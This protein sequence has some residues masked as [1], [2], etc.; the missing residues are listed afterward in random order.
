MSILNFSLNGVRVSLH[1]ADPRQTLLEYVRDTAK[2]TGTKRSCL[3]GGCGAC[4]V[5]IQRFDATTNEW[6]AKPVNACLKPLAS[7]DG[8]VI[9]TVEGIGSERRGCHPVQERIAGHHG[10]QCGFCT[11]GFVMSAFSLLKEHGAPTAKQVVESF[12]GNIC[13][14]T[15]YRNLMNVS[16]SFS[17]EAS[18]GCKDLAAL[19]PPFDANNERL[20]QQPTPPAPS[21]KVLTAGGVTWH[22]PTSLKELLFLKAKEPRA[23]FVLGDTAKGIRSAAYETFDGKAPH[24][25]YLGN[26]PELNILAEHSGNLIAGGA[27]RIQHLVDAL[28]QRSSQ[29]PYAKHMAEAMTCIAQRHL[30]AEA[31]WAGNLWIT[32]TGFPG[33]LF[34]ILLAADA[35]VSYIARNEPEK[36]VSLGQLA[37]PGVVPPSALLTKL[38]IPLKAS[39]TFRYYRVGQRQF[40]SRSLA[41][42]AF[43]VD[44]DPSTRKVREA[45]VAIGVYALTPKRVASAEKIIVGGGLDTQTL[46]NAISAVHTE[47]DAEFSEETPFMTVNNPEGKDQYRRTLPDSFLFKFFQEAQ[48]ACGLKAWRLEDLGRLPTVP[49]QRSELTF[50]EHPGRE[51][52]PQLSAP[53][54]ATGEFRY[55]DDTPIQSLYGCL[56]LSECATGTLTGIDTSEALQSEGVLGVITATDIPGANSCGFVPGEEPVFVPVGGNIMTVGQQIAVVVATSYRLAKRAA[57]VVK[58]SVDGAGH[59]ALT[60]LEDAIQAKS[61]LEGA[62]L[63][64]VNQGNAEEALKKAHRVVQ[65][66]TF[67]QGQHA[68]PMEKQATLAVPEERG[69]MTLYSATQAADFERAIVAGV[70][71]VHGRGS[72][73]VVK[74]ARAGGGFGAKIS[75]NMPVAAAAAVAAHK[76]ER[77]VRIAPTADEEQ[78]SVGGRHNFKAQYEV[79]F[80]PDGRIQGCKVELWGNGGCTHDFSGFLFLEVAEAVSGV[81]DW[82]GNFRVDLHGMRTNVPSNSA[83]RAFGNP[84]ASHITQTILESVASAVGRPIEDIFEMNMMSAKTAF[85]PTGQAMD[86]YNADSLFLKL[87]SDARFL[88][89]SAQIESFNRAHRWRKRGISMVPLCYGHTYVYA[90]GT[91]AQVNVN[92]SDGS[93]TV[94]HGGCEI[95]QGIHTKVA[96]V[97]ALT[98]GCPL[99]VVRVGHTNTEIVPNARFTGGSI[100]SE[101]VCESARR[102][103]FQ[104]N[105]VLQKHRADLKL[106]AENGAEP[107]FA[108]VVA[109]ANGILGN[110]ELLSKTGVYI[111]GGNKYWMNERGEPDGEHHTNYF[112]FGAGCSEVEVD[113]LT[114]EMRILRSDLLYD[115]GN[116]LNP[117][118]DIG[119]VEGAFSFGV[120][121]YFTEEPLFD[122]RGVEMS[123]GVWEYKPPMATEMPVELHVELLR[124]NPYEKGVLGSKAVGEPPFMLA[125]SAVGAVK[126]AIASARSD[127]SLPPVQDISLPLSVDKIKLAC[128][129]DSSHFEV[130][131]SQSKL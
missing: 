103:C 21:S 59:G 37:S 89:R 82:G 63:I 5:N 56:V 62:A 12:D 65:G 69:G 84:Q 25:L 11:P 17:H 94:H 48:A 109:Q 50:Q 105:E 122:K 120:G 43:F 99:E 117:G 126:K 107:T 129:A 34:T 51:A 97:V 20:V 80:A 26:V 41:N 4:V 111:P 64:E 93:V 87:K 58:V 24:L 128:G 1:D 81:F 79:G 7:C 15:G 38:H 100:A 115:V 23:A 106:N 40:L 18:P 2:L 54:L 68:F 108:E 46:K 22:A 113:V 35:A 44:V 116:S 91:S 60:S 67:V 47:L 16:E 85:H 95:G 66:E 30:R 124:D 114:G 125:Y 112:T 83:V 102:A 39:G 57:A 3:Q 36:T 72:E 13:R 71:N 127:A 45:R 92:G 27:V 61:V 75:R 78:V 119:Q 96:Q 28:E 131:P 19:F 121:Y 77:P 101:V 14:C 123:Q 86:F 130:D 70:L 90:A 110:Q 49:L 10:M 42:G 31:G 52:K 55:T 29:V 8:A 6:I 53:A 76:L 9:T 74:M 88:E 33:D 32:R 73:V 98:L 118:I 104:I